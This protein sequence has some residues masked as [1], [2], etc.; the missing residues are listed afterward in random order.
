MSSKPSADPSAREALASAWKAMAAHQGITVFAVLLYTVVST[1]T[2]NIGAPP[3]D[4]AHSMAGDQAALVKMIVTQMG[5]SLVLTALL[6]PLLGALAVYAGKRTLDE[7]SGTLYGGL[8]FALNRYLRIFKWYVVV[9]L[10]VQIGMQ[11]FVL[12][13]ILFFQMYA[14]VVPVLC[15][16]REAWPLARSKRLTAGKRRT[17]FVLMLPWLLIGTVGA[18]LDPTLPV[19]QWIATLMHSTGPSSSLMSVAWTLAEGLRCFYEFWMSTALY[20][21]YAAVIQRIEELRAARVSRSDQAVSES[22][23]PSTA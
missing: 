17:I 22:A 3:Q 11:L 7:D 5:V 18:A 12:P 2:R 6:S 23:A 13:G 15:L 1:L 16:E 14:F 10:S 9:T 4:S 20:F 19:R 8:N 21:L